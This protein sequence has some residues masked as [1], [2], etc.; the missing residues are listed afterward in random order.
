VYE[1]LNLVSFNPTDCCDNSHRFLSV[2]TVPIVNLSV[3]LSIIS[4]NEYLTTCFVIRGMTKNNEIL[5]LENVDG[6][7]YLDAPTVEAVTENMF[8]HIRKMQSN[9]P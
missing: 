7:W 2:K 6:Q 3:L 4:I 8:T 1:Y 5:S 9:G